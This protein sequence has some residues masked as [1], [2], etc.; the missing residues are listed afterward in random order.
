MGNS[1]HSRADELAVVREWLATPLGASLLDQEIRV[2]EEALDG[3]FGEQCLQVGDWGDAR[4]FLRHSRT[5]RSSLIVE[6]PAP[7]GSSAIGVPHRLPVD[8]DS[9]DSV[10]LPHTLDFSDRPHA[11]LREVHRV[12]RASGHLVVLGFRPGGLWGLRRLVP[13]AELPPGSLRLVSDRRL[14]D[15]LKLLDM[16]IHGVTRYFFRWPL[17]GLKGKAS[18]HWEQRGRRW[19]PE[20]SAC[21]MLS[22]Q[23]RISTLTPVRPVWR[24]NPKVVA[25]LAEPSTRVSRIRFDQKNTH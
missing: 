17:P 7:E 4:I 18:A 23:K 3:V 11:V 13:G 25:G 14:R 6:R 21:Y 24:R 9:I 19:W 2:V 8:S 22:A 12:L 1:N 20:L 5:Q 16:R 15:W 10:I